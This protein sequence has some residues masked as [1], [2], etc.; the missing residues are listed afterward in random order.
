MLFQSLRRKSALVSA[1]SSQILPTFVLTQT[2]RLYTSRYTPAETPCSGQYPHRPHFSRPQMRL[3]LYT[4]TRRY[5]TNS[6]KFYT[7]LRVLNM[8]FEEAR[9]AIDEARESV[10]T[11]YYAE[12][13]EDAEKVTQVALEK[14]KQLLKET[15][16]E[17]E[18]EQLSR[19]HQQR[20]KQL[21]EE[22]KTLQAP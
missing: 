6:E 7:D 8:A 1:Q 14:Y 9:T 11:T 5:V 18:R 20:M 21:E 19:E 22:F 13:Y 12:D 10:G 3:Q 2:M 4:Q 17:S 16:D 15:T